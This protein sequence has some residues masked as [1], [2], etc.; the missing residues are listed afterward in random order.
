MIETLDDIAQ[1]TQPAPGG[2]KVTGVDDSSLW[3]PADSPGNRHLVLVEEW[4]LTNTLDVVPYAPSLAEAKTKRCEEVNAE[5]WQILHPT[6]WYDIRDAA[7]GSATPVNIAQYRESVRDTSN[8]VD[9][10]INA[11]TTINEVRDYTFSWPISP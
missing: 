6:D 1:V 8:T 4:L 2:Y 5:A 10:D 3:V 11:L 7:G 9:T